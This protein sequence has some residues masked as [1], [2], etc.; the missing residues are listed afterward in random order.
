[1]T[2]TA[3]CRNVI[4][5]EHTADAVSVAF[6]QFCRLKKGIILYGLVK[7]IGLYCYYKFQHKKYIFFSK[8]HPHIYSKIFLIIVKFQ[9]QHPYKIYLESVCVSEIQK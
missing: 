5:I 8:S 9:P 3:S 6:W 7:N 2:R 4:S 1:M